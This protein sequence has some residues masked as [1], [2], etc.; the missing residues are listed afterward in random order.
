LQREVGETLLLLLPG[1]VSLGLAALLQSNATF[2][3]N[4]L[5]VLF[6]HG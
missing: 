5:V 3:L 4:D 2:L 1:R 6:A